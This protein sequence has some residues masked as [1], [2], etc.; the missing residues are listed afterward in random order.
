[1]TA[2]GT[3][4][5]DHDTGGA[6]TALTRAGTVVHLD[7]QTLRAFAGALEGELV[8]PG[9]G[10][11]EVDRKVWNGMID[12]SPALIVKCAGTED[13]RATVD[14]ARSHD[15]QM[16][17]R[18]GGH[19]AAGVAVREQGLVVDLT[20]MKSV[21]V[22]P[23]TGIV[24]AQGGVT[25]G[26]LDAATQPYGLAVPQGVVTETG[27]AGLTL[28]GGLGWL[29]RR[30]GLA[31]DNLVAAEVVTADGRIVRAGE[32]ENPELLW[33]LRGGGGNFGIVTSFDLQGHAVGP[34]VFFAVV[35]HPGDDVGEALRFYRHWAADAPQ[36]ISAIAV[37]GHAAEI[38]EIPPEHQGE[39]TVIF[40]AMHAGS[41][42][43]GEAA[44]RSLR[45]FGSPIVDFSGVLPYLEVQ[46]FFD[47]DYPKWEKR[48][49]W[50][51]GYLTELPDEAIER[52]VELNAAALSP[53][54]TIDV[55]QL[56]GAMAQVSA[57]ATAFG[58]R[59]AS[60]MLG[61]EANWED[62]NDDEANMAWARDVRAAAE[63]WGTGARYANFPGL[64]EADESPDFFGANHERLA[65]LKTAYDPDNVF[66]RNHN[67]APEPSS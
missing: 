53:E 9:D 16:S 38:D 67:V 4:T 51:S 39:P 66:D 2:T 28:G 48:Y 61:I 50:T 30:F 47:E 3:T 29:R 54:S 10:T 49:Y 34:E 11:Y 46:Q 7:H 56:G 6:I 63:P 57:D 23:S 26:E 59:S 42:A 55:W 37:M 32:D 14:F 5:N 35:Y 45:D 40:V 18:G 64:Y 41:P 43:E 33:G 21:E 15:I 12:V 19:N 27:V 17:V 52:L 1:M 60:F 58:D 44:L 25:I 8:R 31:C 13:V 24:R 22:D 36:D 62:A 20:L 65:A